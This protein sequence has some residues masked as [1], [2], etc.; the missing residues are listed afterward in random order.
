[1]PA[2]S[3]GGLRIAIIGA[4]AVPGRYGGFETFASE[5][6]PRLVDRGHEVTVYCRRRYSLA[7]CPST[8]RGVR[9]QYLPALYTRSLETLSHEIMSGLHAAMGGFDVVFV[10]GFRASFV[11]LAARLSGKQVVVNTD[12]FDWKRRKWGRAGR[13][14]LRLA[15]AIGARLVASRLVC[16]SRALQ[17]HYLQSYGRSSTYISYGTPLYRSQDPGLIR[18]YGLR[19]D[20]YFLVVARLEPENNTDIIIRE[21]R[22]LATD[23]PLAIVGGAGYGRGYDR[24]LRAAGDERVRFLGPIYQPGHLEELYANAFAY[25]HGHEVGG[26]NPALLQAMGCGSAILALDV[27]FNREVVDDTGLLWTKA[28]GNLSARLVQVLRSPEQVAGLK[29]GARRRA[30][31]HYCWERVADGY[32]VLFREV[33]GGARPVVVHPRE[34]VAVP[35]E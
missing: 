29:V 15:E 30:V 32:D 22:K 18:A 6:A 4:R 31:Q 8:Y 2:E 34:A 19:P 12:G 33:A 23:K 9:L 5:L 25:V 35:D 20:G 3:G 16:D 21:Y 26:T 13:T 27:P 24:S 10:L 1:V 7:S 14:Y 11:H 28:E 17:P